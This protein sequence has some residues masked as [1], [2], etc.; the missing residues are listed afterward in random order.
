MPWIL[1]PAPTPYTLHLY[2]LDDGRAFGQSV[3][4]GLDLIDP[5]IC[6]DLLWEHGIVET[7][8]RIRLTVAKMEFVGA[9]P[10]C[11]GLSF[12]GDFHQIAE[13]LVD[14]TIVAET[15][16]EVREQ[17]LGSRV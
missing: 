3:D 9:A 12:P 16:A 2:R 13:S 14:L 6:S 4:S 11:S 17:T 10:T 8:V 7:R 1:D 5:E 15:R